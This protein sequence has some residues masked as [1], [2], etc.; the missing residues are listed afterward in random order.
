[1]RWRGAALAAALAALAT[2][3]P[4][5]AA[6]TC[7]EPGADE[8]QR[9]TPAE[10]GLDAAKLQ[11]AIDYASTQASYA[12][13]VYRHGCLVGED[14]AAAANRNTT[15]ESWSMG[16]SFTSLVFGRA[17]SLGYI[18]PDDPVGALVPEADEAH[19][20]ITLRHL[21]T[22][23]SGLHWNGFRD[24][25]I[26]TMP[27]R[28]HDALTLPVDHPPGTYFEYA[29]SPV[30]LLAEAIGRAVDEDPEDFAQRELL[31]PLGI[32]RGTWDWQ[33][34]NAH[35]VQ[36]FTG[37][38]MR[39]DD[40]GKLGELLRRK[41]MWNGRRLLAKR[42]VSESLTP[43]KTN[44]CYGFL[45][46]LNAGKPCISPTITERGVKQ[47]R[48]WPEFP[49]DM[50]QFSGLF[51]QRVTTF[52]S[53]GLMVVRT[54]Q[55]PALVPA[56]QTNWEYETY[57]RLLSAMTDQKVE[58]PPPATGPDEP[59]H[60]YGFQTAFQHPED[61]GKGLVIFQDPLPPAGPARARA[62]IPLQDETRASRKGTVAIKLLCPGNWPGRSERRCTGTSTLGSTTSTLPYDIAA[63][64]HA[65]VRFTLT[66]K[67]FRK[68]RK[69][70]RVTL[71]IASQNGDTA[72]STPSRASLV[73]RAP[74]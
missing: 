34:D 59:E 67:A 26:F 60:D 37:V 45:H 10:A 15:F 58:K 72:G 44:G 18:S 54:G 29:Q 68:L 35:R 39:P 30:A 22:M 25:N 43:S 23:S 55:D 17:M 36:G 24:Y 33:R 65:T 7:A 57:R 42:Y 53:L 70:R 61:Y 8:W 73:V 20:K 4:A 56:G 19:G 32:E 5:Q 12:V 52:P 2:A 16:K 47:T 38:E 41:G 74:H 28:V 63:G 71:A 11:D 50:W 48:D 13:R 69:T 14:R 6:K 51:G 40:F 27:D 62:A 46:W 1:M 3:A 31:D 9:A 49:A 66:A 21:L 64:R